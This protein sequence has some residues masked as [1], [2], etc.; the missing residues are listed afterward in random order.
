MNNF[1]TKLKSDYE[2]IWLN[3][4]NK[5]QYGEIIE[6]RISNRKP[7][8]DII[9][10]YIGHSKSPKVLEIGCGTGI[11]INIIRK[12]K[13][14]VIAFGSDISENSI[15]VGRRVS[16]GF[17]NNIEFFVADTLNLPLRSDVLDM[18]FSQGLVEHFKDP[19]AVVREQMRVLRKGGILIVNVPQ[20]YTGYTLMKKRLMRAR[21]WDLGWETEFS[22]KDLQGIGKVL[23]LIENGAC[24]YQYWKSWREPA[25]VLRDLYDKLDR[26]N[27]VRKAKPFLALKRGY[28]TLCRRIE[29]RWG[30]WFLQNIVVGFEKRDK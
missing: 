3:H 28:D 29:N 30:H 18:I 10:E 26:R 1:Q 7:Y 23:G 2:T 16:R 15:Q 14:G 12:S 5:A 22:Y 21:K 8:Y 11:D 20:K 13:E 6:S 19:L 9:N 4:L 27:P 25:F 24:G 17:G